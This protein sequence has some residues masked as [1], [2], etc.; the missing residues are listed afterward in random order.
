MRK[1]P[2]RSASAAGGTS[3]AV[4]KSVFIRTPTRADLAQANALVG[5]I[6]GCTIDPSIPDCDDRARFRRTFI[7]EADSQM[8]GVC[9]MSANWLHP[10]RLPVDVVVASRVRRQGIGTTL[11]ERLI[12]EVPTHDHRPLKAAC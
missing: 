7:A 4:R 6:E 2:A 5:S 12:D 1:I 9:A 8:V 3:H 10:R 11:L